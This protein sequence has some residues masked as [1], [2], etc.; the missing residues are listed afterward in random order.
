MELWPRILKLTPGP[1]LE[2]QQIALLENYELELNYTLV[3][4]E[5]RFMAFLLCG[6]ERV[7]SFVYYKKVPY[8]SIGDRDNPEERRRLLTDDTT[9]Y[10]FSETGTNEL[11]KSP[12]P[13]SPISDFPDSIFIERYEVYENR[14]LV[15][16]ILTLDRLDVQAFEDNNTAAIRR[17]QDESERKIRELERD[18]DEFT[19]CLEKLLDPEL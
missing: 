17:V 19:V 4:G 13:E 5:I 7:T 3:N 6:G 1:F 8:N 12:F 15:K 2:R 14:E 9:A 10:A 11:I 16:R 18:Y